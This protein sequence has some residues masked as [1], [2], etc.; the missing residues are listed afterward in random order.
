MFSRLRP[1]RLALI[2]G[3]MAIFGISATASL[4][5]AHASIQLYGEH[6][7]VNGYGV[8]FVRIPHGC[9]GGLPTDTIVVS[10]PAGFASVRPQYLG[11]WA[12]SRT[13]SGSTVTEVK[14]TG[15]SLPDS[16]FADFGISVKYPATAGAYGFKVVQYCGSA[17]VTWDGANIPTLHVKSGLEPQAAAISATE[18]DKHLEVSIDALS[19]YADHKVTLEVS[20]EGVLVRKF[21]RVLDERGDLVTEIALK[22]TNAQGTKYVIR[23]GSTV[24]VKM[25]GNTIGSATMGT[26]STSGGH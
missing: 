8:I 13:M 22:G 26:A 21:V 2:A 19:V 11:G 18:H 23:E 12:A 20:S 9:T 16:Q 4:V 15:G 17:S 1:L 14:W 5:S 10:I 6:A 24:V 7:T 25:D 3:V